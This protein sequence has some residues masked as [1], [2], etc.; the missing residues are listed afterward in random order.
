MAGQQ[1]DDGGDNATLKI[2]SMPVQVSDIS[3]RLD[4]K[5][6][7]V[8]LHADIRDTASTTA[9]IHRA[10]KENGAEI[11]V[12]NAGINEPALLVDMNGQLEVSRESMDRVFGTNVFGVRY[13]ASFLSP[14]QALHAP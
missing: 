6:P 2:H 4:C 9:A 10:V 14:A 12:N 13:A 5:A 11:L 8:Y 3:S 7:L 1:C